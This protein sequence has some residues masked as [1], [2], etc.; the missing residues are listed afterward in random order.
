M[1]LGCKSVL[2]SVAIMFATGASAGTFV[3]IGEVPGSVPNSTAPIGISDSGVV[4]GS[5]MGSD[6]SLHGFI[7]R[8]DGKNY[9]LFDAGPGTNGTQPRGNNS[10]GWVTGFSNANSCDSVTDCA[11]FERSPSGN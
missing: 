7:G 6:L 8:P 11:E 4:T 2:L 3:P 10:Q 5:Y 1:S 9:T